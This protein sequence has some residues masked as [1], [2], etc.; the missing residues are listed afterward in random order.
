MTDIAE[1][2][3]RVEKANG[4]DQ[5]L[6]MDIR[7]RFGQVV[8]PLPFTPGYGLPMLEFTSSMDAVIALIDKEMPER[9]Y[10]L[11]DSALRQVSR[12][13]VEGTN[14]KQLTTKLPRALL[15]AFLRAMM[16]EPAEA[17]S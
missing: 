9:I 11:M 12:D 5:E 15:A 13:S 14:R 10:S 6:D 17:Q 2:L 8:R 3:E 7:Y 4:P 1:L 16:E